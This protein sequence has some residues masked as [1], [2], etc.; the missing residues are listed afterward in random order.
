MSIRKFLNIINESYVIEAVGHYALRYGDKYVQFESKS[1]FDYAYNILN[2]YKARVS[3]VDDVLPKQVP[4]NTFSKFYKLNLDELH[5]ETDD[6]WYDILHDLTMN[7]LKK[8][9]PYEMAKAEFEKVYPIFKYSETDGLHSEAKDDLYFAFENDADK[10]LFDKI[11]GHAH[12][13][14]SEPTGDES[15]TVVPNGFFDN[16]R[17]LV[18]EFEQ[19][20]EKDEDIATEIAIDLYVKMF[21]ELK[22][23]AS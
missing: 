6:E 22:K 20:V 13:S 14:V 19:Y 18:N 17:D 7:V 8:I 5:D 15:S 16:Y 11:I 1:D 12:G 4:A 9:K 21:D 3:K 10:E 2:L 23:Y